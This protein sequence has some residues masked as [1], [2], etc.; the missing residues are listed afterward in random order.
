MM[1]VVSIL[2]SPLMDKGNTAMILT[3]F[4][5]GLKEGGADV[6][7]FYTRKLNINACK[8][9]I[10]CWVKTPGKCVQDDDMQMLL[11]KLKDADIWVLATPLY[12]D[13]MTGPLKTIIDRSAPLALP[14]MEVYEDHNYHL[15]R[16]PVQNGKIVLVA[17]CGF[18]ELDHFDP[19]LAFMKALCR[20]I[21]RE[22]AGALLRPHGPSM[23][24]VT[25]TPLQE[26]FAAARH[27]GRE[28]AETDRISRELVDRVAQ[29]LLPR[30]TYI[31]MINQG[32]ENVL[33]ARALS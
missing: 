5:E 30:E 2:G 6:D 17:N 28:L 31:A 7:L 22:F 33:H 11:P 13:G 18:W 20:N 4:L 23:R 8:G 3:P 24:F 1:K 32:F 9:D 21:R 19:L 15:M 16:E 26:V 27:A 10:G 12:M 25:S 14:F 29:P